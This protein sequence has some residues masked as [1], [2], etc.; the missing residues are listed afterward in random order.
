MG[1]MEDATGLSHVSSI[2]EK[3]VHNLEKHGLMPNRVEDANK[4]RRVTMESGCMLSTS[5]DVQ[6][7]NSESE[8]EEYNNETEFMA[9]SYK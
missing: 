6:D 4:D 3:E 9:S 5:T 8:V 1:D 7:D 2:S